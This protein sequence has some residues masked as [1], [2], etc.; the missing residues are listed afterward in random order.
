MLSPI[1]VK[2]NDLDQLDLGS[3]ARLYKASK[4]QDTSEL[5]TQ[6]YALWQGKVEGLLQLLPQKPLF[7]LI[8]SSPPYNIGKEYETRQALD[9][10]LQWQGKIIDNLVPRLKTGGS[11]CW[12][13]GTY[14]DDNQI[15]PDL[16]VINIGP[17]L[18]AK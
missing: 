2:L 5:L 11:L 14:V 10:Y 4:C 15:W 7:D 16:I 9:D 12:Q 13:V 3:T 18:P 8:V 6:D 1:Q 17:H